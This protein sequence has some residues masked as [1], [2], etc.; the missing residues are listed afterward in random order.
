MAG[1]L[2]VLPA[3]PAMSTTEV[4]GDGVLIPPCVQTLIG[5]YKVKHGK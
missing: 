5:S 1:P 3:G 2:G 4:E